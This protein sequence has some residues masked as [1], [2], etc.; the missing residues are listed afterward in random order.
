[1]R[2]L[3]L[4][5]AAISTGALAVAAGTIPAYAYNNYYSTVKSFGN[6]YS[7]IDL[8]EPVFDPTDST[9]HYAVPAPQYA[10][11]LCWFDAEHGTGEATSNR[12]F[13]MRFTSPKGLVGVINA[14]YVKDQ[15][16]VSH[17]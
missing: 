15:V 14:S 13:R 1:M 9:M 5:A 2:K 12:W 7:T 8:R 3:T 10:R 16:I 4:G 17:C 11:M 6:G